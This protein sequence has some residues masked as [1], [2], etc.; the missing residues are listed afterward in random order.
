MSVQV[1]SYQVFRFFPPDLE[2]QY[3]DQKIKSI[4]PSAYPGTPVG[5]FT[6][7]HAPKTNH[8]VLFCAFN[9]HEYIQVDPSPSGPNMTITVI[10]SLENHPF[11]TSMVKSTPL[12]PKG[13]T[14]KTLIDRIKTKQYDKYRFA[15]EGQGCR[16][17]IYTIINMLKSEG[18]LY[19]IPQ[20]DDALD[21]IRK[22]WKTKDEQVPDDEATGIVEGT[23]FALE[24]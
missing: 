21:A 5:N 24:E 3:A 8:W 13:L 16:H 20:V 18:R 22:I 14:L 17:W 19:S 23:F 6:G 7:E 10:F 12:A 1:P 15:N 4:Y 9:D 2:S 11:D